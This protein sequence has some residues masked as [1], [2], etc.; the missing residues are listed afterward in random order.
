MPH[1]HHSA[2]VELLAVL[3]SRSFWSCPIAQQM[4]V[5]PKRS[6]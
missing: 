6:P 4:F 2:K 5:L 3:A 1:H